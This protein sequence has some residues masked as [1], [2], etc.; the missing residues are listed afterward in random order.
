[1]ILICWQIKGFLL[2]SNMNNLY[3]NTNN[4]YTN[5]NNLFTYLIMILIC[6]QIKGFRCFY[7]IRIIFKQIL[8]THRWDSNRFYHTGS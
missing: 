5:T 1:M 7:L 2:L 4:L 3:T 6:W 8:L